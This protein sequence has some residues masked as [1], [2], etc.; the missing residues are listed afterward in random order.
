MSREHLEL[1]CTPIEEPCIQVRR[2]YYYTDAMKR[3]CNIFKRQLERIFP[4]PP[5]CCFKI[6]SYPHDFGTYCEVVA[7]FDGSDDDSCNWAYNAETNLPLLWDE[8]AR[9]ELKDP[10]IQQYYN[11]F[12]EDA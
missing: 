3:E 11:D 2:D 1:S 5:G 9:E 12:P 4:S 8:V 6:N 7:V 10:V